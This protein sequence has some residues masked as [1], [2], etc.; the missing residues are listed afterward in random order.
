LQDRGKVNTFEARVDDPGKAGE[1]SRLIDKLFENSSAPTRS[2]P[3]K[4]FYESGNLSGI[5]VSDIG[6]V[7]NGT[8]AAGVF[9]MLFLIGNTITQ[10]VR[11]RIPEFA[12]MKALGFSDETVMMLVLAEA[13]VPSLL[14]AAAG[15]LIALGLSP[16]WP[17]II[18]TSWSMPAPSI[19]PG[20]I[21]LAIL[22]SLLIAALCALIPS[23]RLKRLDVA[24]A[25]VGR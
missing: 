20:V 6:L 10:S 21:A 13:T 9:M 22:F 5:S 23:L 19:S 16:F 24:S 3:E 14:G 25:L 2:I 8:A 12:V 1:V 11:E 7:T 18:P 17:S 15:L 4:T